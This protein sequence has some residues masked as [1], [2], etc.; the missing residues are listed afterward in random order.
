MRL[1]DVFIFF[2]AV[3]LFTASTLLLNVN[4]LFGSLD[5]VILDVIF[6]C[7]LAFCINMQLI[8]TKMKYDPCEFW[9]LNWFLCIYP[10]C[11]LS[12]FVAVDDT[13][14]ISFIAA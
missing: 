3:D 7:C 12:N 4:P 9:G 14:Y 6:F 10:F 11:L 1:A 2:A 5:I 13:S 8:C